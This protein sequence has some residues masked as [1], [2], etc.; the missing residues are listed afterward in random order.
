MLRLFA[1]ALLI[2]LPCGWLYAAQDSWS[3][4]ERLVAIGDVH[5]DHDQ[6]FTLLQ[7]AGLV[8][9][10]GR[11][12]GGKT[13]LVQTGDVPDRGPD[14]RKIMDLLIRLEKQAS[15]A[16]GRVHALIG[17]HEAM[18]VYTDLR[19]VTPEE[20]EAFRDGNSR[21]VRDHFWAQYA[22]E[23]KQISADPPDKDQWYEEHPLGY[24]EHRFAYGPKGKY[25]KWI[26]QHNAVVKVND[27][28]FLHGGISPL[29]AASSL[30]EINEKVRAELE[31]FRL[32]SEGLTMADG[33]PLWYR[34][35]ANGDEAELGPHVDAVLA[36]YGVS[37]IVVGHTPTAGTVMPR[38][39]GKVLM[40]DV[41]LSKHHGGRLACLVIENGK[42]S[43]LHRGESMEIPSGSDAGLLEYLEKAA[44]LDP[45]PSPLMSLI[46]KL[47]VPAA[48]AQ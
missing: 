37:R 42:P 44:A 12:M 48:A 16:G 32:L 30:K 9:K 36:N 24:F 14:T 23:Q 8:N 31:D 5:G 47:A 33:G 4:V 17:N 20:Y 26:R 43:V 35:L 13:H 25:G 34:G 18:N 7:Q 41:G 3:G 22:E 46:Q 28:L 6:F 1:L 19:Y 11:W 2:Y 15:K 39:G 21:R 40:I 10:K 27:S 29:L 38:F 45:A